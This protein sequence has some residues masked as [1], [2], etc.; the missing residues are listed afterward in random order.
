MNNRIV[1]KYRQYQLVSAFNSGKFL[2][3]VYKKEQN[4][5]DME[6]DSMADV[7]VKLRN[8]VDTLID[9]EAEN[10]KQ[11]TLDEL[12]TAFRNILPKLNDNYL[13]MIRAHYQAPD[14][15]ITATLLA[16][17]AGYDGYSSANLHYGKIGGFLYEELPMD[18]PKRESGKPIYTFMLADAAE[19][20]GT[21]EHWVWKM[22][23]EVAGAIQALGLD[24]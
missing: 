7:Q 21:E 23:L 3:R 11:A 12:V 4:I 19:K 17:A 15:R 22:R 6:G 8:F 16:D 13:A 24:K 1:E 20:I 5:L 10:R 18:I 2:G 14:Q 9:S